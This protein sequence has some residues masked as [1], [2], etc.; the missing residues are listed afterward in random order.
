MN[1]LEEYALARDMDE[2]MKR[3]DS[4]EL[5]EFYYAPGW[6]LPAVIEGKV[7]CLKS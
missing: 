2:M 7:L 1:R 3:F 5:N 4:E 6:L